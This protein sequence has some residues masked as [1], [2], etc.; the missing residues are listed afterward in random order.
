MNDDV[1]I[2]RTYSELIQLPTF[3][4]RFKYLALYGSVGS[5][6]FGHDRYLNQLLYKSDPWLA[7]RD[8]VI[9]RDNGYDLGVPYDEYKI[10]GAVIVHHMNPITVEDILNG[11]DF[12]FNPEYLIST[13][14]I[15]HNAIHYGDETFLE[16]IFE[17]R[18]MNDTLLWKS[19]KD[20]TNER[21]N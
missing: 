19:R 2:I 21:Y 7:A 10:T 8:I 5:D 11:S 20:V 15:T 6:T 18:T 3:E 1:T 16:P 12:L 14:L 13:R 4:E 17:E 9:V